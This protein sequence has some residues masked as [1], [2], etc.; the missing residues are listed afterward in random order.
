M[1]VLLSLMLVENDSIFVL[2][3]KDINIYALINFE[4]CSLVNLKMYLHHAVQCNNIKLIYKII[5]GNSSGYNHKLSFSNFAALTIS[6]SLDER[7]IYN[8]IIT[9]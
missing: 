7:T 5:I 6:L 2:D 3:S 4:G 8:E 1:V 9:R